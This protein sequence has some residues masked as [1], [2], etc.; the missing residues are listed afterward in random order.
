MENLKDIIEKEEKFVIFAAADI[1]NKME[2]EKYKKNTDDQLK[3]IIRLLNTENKGFLIYCFPGNDP[4]K[5][6]VVKWAKNVNYLE[7]LNFMEAM[8]DSLKN[9]L[10]L[11][12]EER[13]KEGKKL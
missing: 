9:M 8:S 7:I 13:L 11:L 10:K 4:N 5:F 6:G 12:I 3:E 2:I 1:N